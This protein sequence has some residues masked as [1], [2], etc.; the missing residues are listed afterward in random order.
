ML[1]KKDI[2]RG[3][4]R[5]SASTEHCSKSRIR[6]SIPGKGCT[7]FKILPL[8]PRGDHGTS[9]I[10]LIWYS[11]ILMVKKWGTRE[12]HKFEKRSEACFETQ[13]V[14]AFYTTHQILHLCP[15]PVYWRRQQRIYLALLISLSIAALQTPTARAGDCTQRT[16]MWFSFRSSHARLSMEIKQETDNV[17]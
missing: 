3:E 10:I 14:P 8:H 5:H 1:S 7:C 12:G 16:S 6:R 2:K 4:Y 17:N 13:D 9:E 15:L 11:W